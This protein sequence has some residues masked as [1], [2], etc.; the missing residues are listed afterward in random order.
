MHHFMGWGRGCSA[1]GGCKVS[2]YMKWCWGARTKNVNRHIQVCEGTMDSRE[3]D[4][5]T[6]MSFLTTYVLQTLKLARWILDTVIAKNSRVEGN[7][8]T[9]QLNFF[10]CQS[11]LVVEERMERWLEFRYLETVFCKQRNRKVRSGWE[12]WMRQIVGAL[13]S[14]ERKMYEQEVKRGDKEQDYPANSIMC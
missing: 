10:Q 14:Y 11:S 4:L 9:L 7:K 12:Q 1:M 8:I 5:A 3:I 6:F 13:E 2:Y